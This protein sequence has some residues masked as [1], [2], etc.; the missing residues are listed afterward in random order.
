MSAASHPE[1]DGQTECANRVVKDVL[2]NFTTSFKSWS[3][4]L[5][6]LEFTTNNT[7]HA[8]IGLMPFSVNFG[9]HTRVPALLGLECPPPPQDS[10]G[11]DADDSA[12]ADDTTSSAAA[13]ASREGVSTRSGAR[14]TSDASRGLADWTTRMLINPRQRWAVGFEV[15][16]DKPSPAAPPP[17][18][19]A[20]RQQ[21]QPRDAAASLDFVQRRETVTRFVRD[22]IAAAVARQKEY[23]DRRGRKN[24]D[25]FAV[26]DRVLLSTDGIKPTSVTNFG[27]NR[28]APRYIGSFKVLKV[29]DD[30]Y[31]LQL[32]T[33]LHLH[34]TFYVG[35]LRRHRPA[36]IPNDAV[37]ASGRPAAVRSAPAPA[38]AHGA[39][40]PD[41]P[42]AAAPSGEPSG[43]DAARARRP[44]SGHV[45]LFS[46]TARHRLLIVRGM[47]ATS[48]KRSSATTTI[49][50]AH[51]SDR[52]PGRC[53]A[54]RDA[55]VQ[56][57]RQ[58]LV[59][60]LG[61]MEDS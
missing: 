1:T 57:L 9:Q 33:A 60:W 24:I 45:L 30:V 51:E 8:L 58:Y 37:L 42:A 12:P 44:P 21:P 55:R 16:P 53:A 18:N 5:P 46:T 14:A 47:S 31:T 38:G 11:D 3:S 39:E 4:F 49:A 25:Q 56:E 43:R 32:L 29:L 50:R 59:R 17:A 13:R 27:A 19:F 15:T 26:G 35:R 40:V 34:P 20:P 22:A 52:H 6:M 10:N 7:V 36:T 28:I 48:W 23:A 61:P 2:R 41:C 54:H